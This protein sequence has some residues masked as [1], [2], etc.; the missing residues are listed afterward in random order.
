MISLTLHQRSHIPSLWTPLLIS[1]RS[2]RAINTSVYLFTFFYIYNIQLSF[3]VRENKKWACYGKCFPY[4]SSC[5]LSWTWFSIH[6][7]HQIPE[8]KHKILLLAWEL[9]YFRMYWICVGKQL[10]CGLVRLLFSRDKLLIPSS[11]ALK[12]KED[13]VSIRMWVK[14]LCFPRVMD[15]VHFLNF[16]EKLSLVQ[17]I[18]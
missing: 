5:V 13:T 6:S 3:V 7:H 12:Y 16:L 2:S 1:I 15:K 11:D 4:I 14:C 17:L 10:P 9:L 8:G 18:W